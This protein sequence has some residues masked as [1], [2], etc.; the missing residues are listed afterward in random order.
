MK[1]FCLKHNKECHYLP[2]NFIECISICNIIADQLILYLQLNLPNFIK[3]E[4]A[5]ANG[6]YPLFKL[7]KSSKI[8]N[9]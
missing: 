7:F 2:N 6:E 8:V 9:T 5:D 4:G 3:Q 1:K